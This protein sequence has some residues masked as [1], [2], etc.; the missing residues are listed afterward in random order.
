MS[1]I[2]LA[3]ALLMTVS[4]LWAQTTS[5]AATAAPSAVAATSPASAPASE[6]ADANRI[7][8]AEYDLMIQTVGLTKEQQQQIAAL[9]TQRDK[10]MADWKAANSDKLKT[11]Q[12]DANDIQTRHA[13][14][15]EKAL[16]GAAPDPNEIEQAKKDEAAMEKI[17]TEYMALY[18]PLQKQMEEVRTQMLTVLTPE[19]KAKWQ[20]YL[21]LT[22]LN[23]YFSPAKLTAEQAKQVKSIYADIAKD[24][25]VGPDMIMFAMAKK[26]MGLLTAEQKQALGAVRQIPAGMDEAETPTTMTSGA[27]TAPAGAT[28][29][30]AEE[31]KK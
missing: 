30:P 1:R 27:T 11:L 9:E 4:G 10:I 12:G 25:K 22:N 19:Q 18:E 7:L 8:R 29:K 21:I 23:E 2:A 16:P 28:S 3:A 14:A 31:P 15:A 17:Q 26:V 24:E 13:K 6:P 20:E 5:P